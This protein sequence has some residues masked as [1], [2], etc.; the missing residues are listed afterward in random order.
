VGF[1]VVEQVVLRV[2]KVDTSISKSSTIRTIRRA[3]GVMAV[4]MEVMI[5]KIYV[6]VI[7][8]EAFRKP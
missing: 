1:L 5:S 3:T 7:F 6:L 2:R 4:T 8:V